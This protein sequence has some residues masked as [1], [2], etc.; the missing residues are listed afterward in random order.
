MV[1]SFKAARLADRLS[2]API[3]DEKH[4]EV[5][6]GVEN[7]ARPLQDVGQDRSTRWLQQI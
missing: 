4:V 2:P 5:E 6:S 3:H 1:G 7:C